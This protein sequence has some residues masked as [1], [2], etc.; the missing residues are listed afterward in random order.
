MTFLYLSFT[1]H[2]TLRTA[3]CGQ[4]WNWKY[5]VLDSNSC[6]LKLIENLFSF[7]CFFLFSFYFGS[8]LQSVICGHTVGCSSNGMN[9]QNTL[10]YIWLTLW[11]S[12]YT[13]SV[14][15]VHNRTVVSVFFSLSLFL[16][17]SFGYVQCD[18]IQCLR[19]TK[20]MI[21]TARYSVWQSKRKRTSSQC[22][23]V[24][25]ITTQ[26]Q[27]QYKYAGFVYSRRHKHMHNEQFKEM[28]DTNYDSFV[29]CKPYEV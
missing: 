3:Q 27:K 10:Y 8:E 29:A 15:A 24:P 13:Q 26:S 18:T 7:R 11:E 20:C 22:T 14:R 12:L 23:H 4:K 19:L 1:L 17:H 21:Y 9:H 28:T 2:H 16:F 25:T 6:D 5:C